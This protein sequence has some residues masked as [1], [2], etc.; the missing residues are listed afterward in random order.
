MG[1]MKEYFSYGF[2]MCGIP[3]VTLE[4][5]KSD[6]EDILR[7][8]ERLK[9]YG[10][11]MVAWYHLLQPIISQFVAAYDDPNSPRNL[12]FW[13]KV[14]HFIEGFSGP[15][16]L[17]GW[18]TASCV[19]NGQGQWQGNMFN[20]NVEDTKDPLQ[21]SASQFASSYLLPVSEPYL[22]LDGFPYPQ[23]DS[24]NVPSEYM[25]VDVQLDDNGNLF[26]T[27]FVAGLIG[28]R[29]SSAV[30]S[31][32]SSPEGVGKRDIVQPIPG[33]WY[34]IKTTCRTGQELEESVNVGP[35]RVEEERK[36]LF[37]KLWQA[38]R[39]RSVE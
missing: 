15:T 2:Q 7:R 36:S 6:W 12:S 26:N 24:D 17:A 13:N 10:V 16:F 35:Q 32:D 18:I 11:Q 8:L 5:K 19:F 4:G 39:D 21:L 30:D 20:Q 27:M 14:C 38:S 31:E 25:Q 1:T 9:R 22:A 33:W 37:D 28:S 29:I 3:K 23:I 34:F